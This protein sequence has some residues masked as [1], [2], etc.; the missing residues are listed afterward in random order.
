MI[1][2]NNINF[3]DP[4]SIAR[5]DSRHYWCVPYSPRIN[6]LVISGSLHD[7]VI[8]I[9]KL[10]EE[11]IQRLRPDYNFYFPQQQLGE[12]FASCK[13]FVVTP[14]TKSLPVSGWSC[15]THEYNKG[16][17]QIFDDFV[18]RYFVTDKVDSP[19]S[20]RHPFF[21]QVLSTLELDRKSKNQSLFAQMHNT[22]RSNNMME[23][24]AV[25]KVYPRTTTEIKTFK[26]IVKVYHDLYVSLCNDGWDKQYILPVF[27]T[28]DNK[29]IVIEGC[30]RSLLASYAN[31]RV[32]IY[33]LFYEH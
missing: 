21:D 26:R 10:T 11:L 18:S 32:P 5:A 29:P 19:R 3:I 22:I 33:P 13:N 1:S 6:Q 17:I 14:T 24:T 12:A 8:P 28:K 7:R 15:A 9:H 31:V 20:I 30:F 27:L 4:T 25:H 16:Y 23:N 2:L